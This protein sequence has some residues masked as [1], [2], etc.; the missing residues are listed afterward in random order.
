MHP[1]D[2]E[3][4]RK[5]RAHD[6]ADSGWFEHDYR[7]I[8]PDGEVRWM[9]SRGNIVRRPDG[10]AAEAYGVTLDVTERKQ[11]EERHELLLGELR[12][13]VQNSLAQ[14]S[15]MVE[16]S[17]SSTASVSALKASITGRLGAMA[18]AHAR[19]SRGNSKGAGLRELVKEELAPY[20]SQ[21]N[22]TVEGPDL[23]II[24]NAA[25]AL[26]MVFQEL[27]TNALKYGALSTPAGRVAVRWELSGENGATQLNLVWQEAG[28]PSV[29]APTREGYGTRLIRNLVRH[30]LGGQVELR[31]APAGVCCEFQLPLARVTDGA[32]VVA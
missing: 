14:I 5:D 24:P 23:V 7:I 16:R 8:R 31:L 10:I 11:A 17:C 1:N 15:V 3:A 6:L 26:G 12:H 4:C 18:R 21:I 13:R 2:I 19:L 22:A 9:C 30:E 25:Q 28:G 29:A 32:A 20:Q 27:A